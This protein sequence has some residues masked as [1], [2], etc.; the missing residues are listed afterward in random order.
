MEALLANLV[1]PVRSPDVLCQVRA[2]EA[3]EHI[4]TPEAMDVLKRLAG[5]AAATR[6][7]REAKAA[8]DRLNRIRPAITH[9]PCGNARS[10]G[11]A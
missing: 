9:R 6:L 7:T 5:G 8:L 11:G 3:L 1:G 2:I 4:G 10:P